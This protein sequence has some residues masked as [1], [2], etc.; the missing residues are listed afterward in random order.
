M[1]KRKGKRD[2]KKNKTGKGK[3]RGIMK[4]KERVETKGKSPP[5]INN[6]KNRTNIGVIFSGGPE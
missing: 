4:T 3:G 2:G 6:K 1:V 5:K